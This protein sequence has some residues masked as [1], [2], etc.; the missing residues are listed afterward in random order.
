MDGCIA[1]EFDVFDEAKSTCKG[2]GGALSSPPHDPTKNILFITAD[3][4]R[5]DCLSALDHPVVKTPNL[6]ALAREG[7]FFARHFANTSPCSPSRATLHTGLYQHNHRVAMNGT[8]LDR[9][10]TNWALEAR[11]LGYDPALI[12][13]TDQT[14]DPRDLQTRRPAPLDLRRHAAGPERDRRHRHGSP[15][16]VG[17]LPARARATNCRTK[18]ASSSGCARAAPTTKTARRIRSPGRARR[19]QRHDLA[20]RPSDRLHQRTPQR[21]VD[22]APVAAAPASAVDRLRT[23]EQALRSGSD[24]AAVAPRDAEDEGAQHPW[25]ARQL[26]HQTPPRAR[27][28]ETARAHAGRLLRHDER[29]RRQSRPPLRAPETRRPV[30]RHAHRLHQRPR[31][32]ARRSLDAGQERLLRPDLRRTAASSAI[33]A[34]T[35]RAARSCA[36][37]PNTSTS[38]RRCSTRS[39]PKSRRNATAAR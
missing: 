21:A 25:L 30:G 16:T 26:K 20:R 39:A 3:Q 38:C 28:R 32:T 11:K 35:P 12:G 4:W 7:V 10:H 1:H 13:Y 33:R 22:P 23:V 19:A 36:P 5:G 31:R 6:D 17:R 24:A 9:R 15:G 8:P 29:G 34:P 27:Q 37:S 18:S 2:D 14:A